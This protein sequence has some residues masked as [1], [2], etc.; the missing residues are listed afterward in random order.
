MLLKHMQVNHI[1]NLTQ[2]RK[3][4]R[5]VYDGCGHP[6]EFTRGGEV[7]SADDHE[8]AVRHVVRHYARC[9]T[10]RL[11]LELKRTAPP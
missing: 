3:Y 9:L 8:W 2:H 7:L 5:L 6:Q 1:G 10:C 4:W 11:K